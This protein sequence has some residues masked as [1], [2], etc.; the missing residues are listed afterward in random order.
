MLR[1]YLTDLFPILELGTSAKMLSIVPLDGRRRLF[2]TGA[3]G[4]APKHVQQFVQENYLRWDS[5]GEFLALAASLEH[6]AQATGNAEALVL[7][8]ALDRA[9]GMILDNDK[10]PQRKVGELDNRGSH[11]YL[12]LYWAQA[13]AAQTDDPELGAGFAARRKRLAA[14]EEPIVGELNAVQGSRSTSAA[15]FLAIEA[16]AVLG[17]DVSARWSPSRSRPR[18]G[19]GRRP[20]PLRRRAPK[21]G[22]PCRASRCATGSDRHPRPRPVPSPHRQRRRRAGSARP[23]SSSTS[24]GRPAPQV[25]GAVMAAAKLP[26]SGAVGLPVRRRRRRPPGSAPEGLEVRR[27][28]Q[29]LPGMRPPSGHHDQGGGG[30]SDDWAGVPSSGAGRWRCSGSRPAT[31]SSATTCRGGSGA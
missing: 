28:Y 5:L 3:G 25:I 29:G 4:S 8:D 9:T 12:A 1:D 30:R 16:M 17:I 6:L 19:P 13:L 14:G 23:S 10:S 7:A 2:E 24:H 22:S 31:P 21:G 27:R 26:P 20:R 11:F 15:T 18:R